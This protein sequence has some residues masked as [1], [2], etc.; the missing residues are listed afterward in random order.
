MSHSLPL[1]INSVIGV[2]FDHKYD[3]VNMVFFRSTG[4]PRPTRP[5]FAAG[6]DQKQVRADKCKAF[7][8]DPKNPAIV[9]KGR[10]LQG[11]WA[12]APYLHNGSVPNLWELLLPPAQR[13]ATFNVG[14]REFD[15]KN[16]GYVTAPSA[17]NSFIFTAR[18]ATGAP[19]QGNSN[20]GHDYGNAKLSDDDRWALIEYMKTL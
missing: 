17:D 18:D 20:G 8:D 4:L 7:H 15:P 5:F 12:T 2:L 16:V 13:S 6:V 9:Y 10:P 3:V 11:I 14:S 1:L 19:V